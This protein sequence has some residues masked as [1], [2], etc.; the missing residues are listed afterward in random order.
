M[1]TLEKHLMRLTYENPQYNVLLSIW[2]LNKSILPLAQSNIIFNFPHYSLHERSHSE[3][4]I[5]NIESFL[6]EERIK[7]LSPTDTWLILMAAHTHDLG[8][9][10]FHKA[11]EEKWIEEEFQNYIEITAKSSRDAD[12]TRAANL[13]LEVQNDFPNKTNTANKITRPLEIRKA[14]ILIISDYFRIVHHQRSRDMIVGAD[15]EFNQLMSNFSMDQIPNRFSTI[16]GEIAYAH[17]IDFYG[18]VDKL[19]YE[20]NGFASDKMHPRFIA[21]LLRLGDLLDIDDKRFNPFTERVFSNTLPKISTTHK[22]KHASTKHFLV[23]P[24]KIEITVD[25]ESDEVYRIAREWFDWLQK[26]VEDQS[27]EWSNIAPENLTGLPPSISRGKLKVLF[28]NALPKKE[29]MNLRF[30]ISNEKIF[31][32]LEGAAIYEDPGFV[33]LREIV[34]NALDANKI[35]L[36]RDIMNGNY[37]ILL[38]Q[39]LK[40][41]SSADINTV[42]QN[43]KYP[44]DIPDSVYSNYQINLNIYWDEKDNN[45]LIFDIIDKGTGIAEA[46][47][48]RMTSK[49]GESRSKDKIFSVFKKQMPYWLK[50]TGA[51]G[52]GLQ[53]IFIVTKE[54]IVHTKSE[55][56][57]AREIRFVTSKGGEYSRVTSNIPEMNRGT[58]I[59]IGIEKVNFENVFG[60]SFSYGI[61][62]NWDYFTQDIG[63]EYVLKVMSYIRENLK[64]VKA[65]NVNVLNNYTLLKSEF[66]FIA[67]ESDSRLIDK[68]ENENFKVSLLESVSDGYFYFF[69]DERLSNSGSRLILQLPNTFEHDKIN[70]HFNRK[71][72]YTIRD[73][74]V[75]EDAPGYYKIAYVKLHW[76]LQN[77][78]S[79]KVLNISRD[80]MI[81]QA[82]HNLNN[83]LLDEIL[84]MALPMV[85]ELFEN[86]YTLLP[87]H[88]ESLSI[89][90]FYLE[91]TCA[92]FSL[93]LKHK[94]TIYN[95]F[96]LPQ[97]AV[98]YND[99]TSVKLIDFIQA[100]DLVTTNRN[101]HFYENET[102]T[103]N[104]RWNQL[105]E[106]FPFILEKTIIVWDDNDFEPY[107]V[108]TG[109]EIKELQYLGINDNFKLL[110]RLLTRDK[111]DDYVIK[112]NDYTK[113]TLLKELFQI[114][115][116][117]RE[118]LFGIYPY[119]SI[120]LKNVNYDGFFWA[121]KRAKSN[122]ISPINNLENLHR[123]KTSIAF[124]LEQENLDLAKEKI[125]SFISENLP[126]KLITWIRTSENTHKD[127]VPSEDAI[128]EDYSQ[129]LLDYF[130]IPNGFK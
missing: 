39:H 81:A 110:V 75:S 59:I 6:G 64:D 79:D 26:E 68:I 32:M 36:W 55:N 90:Y 98:V 84:P 47:I 87:L 91:L 17:G 54:F 8:M 45:K 122:I 11:L 63:S 105:K 29:L 76:N 95:E 92:M 117:R 127:K 94:E 114:H 97:Q 30:A 104:D 96:C 51:F 116:L 18:V 77:P 65:L 126:D 46:D 113:S 15:K 19:E 86:N 14:T 56:E 25:C 123:L 53:S 89:S 42:I 9:V 52:I 5:K 23:R 130:L 10:V 109:F 61:L 41:E 102:K 120:A 4:I 112:V 115:H 2:N 50:P 21:F 16:L 93:K 111:F 40:L 48:I 108:M 125:K 121:I 88:S 44:D 66:A 12:L 38:K 103:F 37:N 73:I 101:N 124:D 20:S 82:K 58:R 69:I 31:E 13:L 129:L 28:G 80:K 118:I 43:I 100:K 24:D 107:T 119:H 3:T 60:K 85:L 7:T 106:N 70:S 78:D 1:Y 22:E 71:N 33:F 83:V 57:T 27:R 35:Q 49:V 99:L 62:D 34:Q 74:P 72:F 128:L 67:I